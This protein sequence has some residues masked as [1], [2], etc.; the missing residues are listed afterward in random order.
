MDD[1]GSKSSP[2][3]TLHVALDNA[4]PAAQITSPPPRAA[5]SD[6]I[7]VA[8]AT[9]EGWT[10]AN[11]DVDIARDTAGRFHSDV[12]VGGKDTFAIRLAHPQRGGHYY[13]RRRK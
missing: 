11:D 5:W 13:V 12:D 10:V 8:G 7:D 4:A 2:R 3:T 6:N 9:V 1:S